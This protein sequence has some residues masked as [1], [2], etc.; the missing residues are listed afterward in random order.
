M[1]FVAR[2]AWGTGVAKRT[3]PGR[4]F[5]DWIRPGDVVIDIGAN[6]GAFTK[7]FAGEVGPDGLV[8]AVEPDH[9]LA[10]F[11]RHV[12]EGKPVV[13]KEVAVSD[14]VGEH[15]WFRAS[16]PAQNSLYREN[17]PSITEESTVH[18]TTLDALMEDIGRPVRAIKVDAQGAEAAIAQGGTKALASK[19]LRWMVEV[20]P[21]GLKAA[22]SS[23]EALADTYERAGWSIVAE[24]KHPVPS[25]LSWRDLLGIV[26]GYTGHQ[27]TNV[28][29][30]RA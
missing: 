10:E 18:T 13:V 16:M 4:E 3:P 8:V 9:R 21:E 2:Y 27:H 12:C 22:G 29:L 11:C 14:T 5:G 26:R 20:W 19:D 28:I 7:R 17:A 23:P 1:R 15:A 25:R 30:A 24:G 6:E